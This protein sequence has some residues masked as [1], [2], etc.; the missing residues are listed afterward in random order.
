M[1]ISGFRKWLEERNNCKRVSKSTTDEMHH[2]FLDMNGLVHSAYDRAQ[3]TAAATRSN[4]FAMLDRIY[5]KFPARA[6]INVIFDGPAP[7][8]KLATQRARRRNYADVDG[9]RPDGMSEGEITT[10]SVFMLELEN[11]VAEH[12][13]KRLSAGTLPCT[14]VFI[15]GTR[16]PGEGET[17]ISRRLMHLAAR[18]GDGAD[19]RRPHDVN[20]CVCVVGNDSDLVLHCVGATPY[21]NLFVVHPVSFVMTSVGDLILSWT[22]GNSAPLSM[23]QLPSARIDFVFLTQLAGCDH[24]DGIEDEAWRA[25]HTYRGLRCKPH[26]ANARLVTPVPVDAN[27]PEL[28]VRMQIN[29]GFLREVLCPPVHGGSHSSHKHSTRGK[30]Q[31]GTVFQQARREWEQQQKS[32]KKG[33][34]LVGSNLCEAALWSLGS[35]CFGV[36]QNFEYRWSGQQGSIHALRKA[37]SSLDLKKV[38]APTTDPRAPPPAPLPL[39]PLQAYASITVRP[40]LLPVALRTLVQ[41]DQRFA[42]LPSLESIT[43][44]LRTVQEL[45]AEIRPSMLTPME[46]KLMSFA[47]P[48]EIIRTPSGSVQRTE[49]HVDS[50]DPRDEARFV[51]FEYSVPQMVDGVE[52]LVPYEKWS[53]TL[54]VSKT[55]AAKLLGGEGADKSDGAAAC[56][57]EGDEAAD[58]ES[59]SSDT[60]AVVAAVD[61]EASAPV[62]EPVA[63]AA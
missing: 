34:P 37:A 4:L 26:R 40:K 24:Y 35:A 57:D 60:S 32:M 58:D 53:V 15:S 41:N 2:L 18:R 59:C 19:G 21:H 45:F 22:R 1:G 33:N 42:R 20:D 10:G 16:V 27:K 11:A 5:N 23:L 48:V 62:A 14:E 52:F 47:S 13:E 29:T 31:S 3:P 43:S 63:V 50:L 49:L 38:C 55:L 51:D 17:K 36:C 8:A 9:T 6:S 25:W 46:Q 56:A 12:L 30:K 7:I 39:L 54:H 61:T 44:V 28:G